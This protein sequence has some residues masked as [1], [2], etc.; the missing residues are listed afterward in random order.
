MLD[1]LRIAVVGASG[2]VGREAISILRERGVPAAKITL[3]GS[4]R[5]AGESVEYGSD[6]LV[7]RALSEESVPSCDVALFCADADTAREF[8][9]IFV[10]RGAYVIDNSSAFRLDS[11]VPLIV[12]EINTDQLHANDSPCIIA[13]PNCSTIIMLT[14]LEPIRR[15]FGVRSVIVSTYQA[16]SGAGIAAID[17]LRTQTRAVLD[18]I[19]IAPSVF[20][21]SC[22]WNVFPHESAIDPDTG[23]CGEEE[24]MIAESR[25]IWDHHN[26]AIVPTCVRV[27]V[28]R[29]HSQSITIETDC[30]A[31]VAEIEHVLRDAP[32]VRFCDGVAHPL[33]TPIHATGQDDVLVGRV[34]EDV[35][36]NGRRFSLWVCGDQ[37]RKGAALNA[38]QIAECLPVGAPAHV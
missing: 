23:L 7:I 38:V 33:A 13:N 5:S 34:R 24:K 29:A 3:F 11:A 19:V 1:Q 35:T 8:A 28:M 16:V 20:P 31:T 2:A 36:S 15:A 12:P 22:G 6:R 30:R 17:E 26:L 32:G 4:S 27:P 25:R 37:L 9:P 21:V 14:A 10:A 18:G